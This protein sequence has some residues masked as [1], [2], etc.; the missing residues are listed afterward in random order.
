MDFQPR[1]AGHRPGAVQVEIILRQHSRWAASPLPRES[2]VGGFRELVVGLW[3]LEQKEFPIYGTSKT[4]W[5]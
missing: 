4:F 3:A 2:R 1:Q 5:K